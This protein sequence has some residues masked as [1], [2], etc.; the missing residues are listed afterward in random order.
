MKTKS[1]P[2]VLISRL[3]LNPR[4]SH[5]LAIVTARAFLIWEG[6]KDPTA[7]SRRNQTHKQVTPTNLQ[8]KAELRELKAPVSTLL[9]RLDPTSQNSQR[10][11]TEGRYEPTA[12]CDSKDSVGLTALSPYTARVTRKHTAV[13]GR[14]SIVEVSLIEL[15]VGNLEVSD[16]TSPE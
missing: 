11:L 3:T 9:T 2:H 4:K 12:T 5:I 6:Q 7:S 8:M 14:D 1:D 16:T 10:Q 13:F 15:T